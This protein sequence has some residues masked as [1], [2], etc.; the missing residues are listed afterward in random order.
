KLTKDKLQQQMAQQLSQEQTK[1]N[2]LRK[3]QTDNV[4]SQYMGLIQS[5]IENNWNKPESS[6]PDAKAKL[7]VKLA[8]GGMVVAVSIA[9]TSGDSA[10]D[11][12]AMNAVYK[13]SPLPVPSDPDIFD[14]YFRQFTITT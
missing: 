3:A 7:L 5:A 12:S 9:T 1:L 13:A 11:Q 10:L 8:P 2:T 6:S 14:Q 4:V